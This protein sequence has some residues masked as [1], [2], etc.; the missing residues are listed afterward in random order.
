MDIEG[1]EIQLIPALVN[2]RTRFDLLAIE[3]DFLSL[4]PFL[5][6][7]TRI[8][9]ICHAR[10]MLKSLK[11]RNYQLVLNENFNFIWI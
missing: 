10:K 6:L 4:I 9:M 3:M 5:S 1:S 8:C 7:W 2:F 11:Q